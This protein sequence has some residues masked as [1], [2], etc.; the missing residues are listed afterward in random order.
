MKTGGWIDRVS[1]LVTGENLPLDSFDE[2]EIIHITMTVIICNG[3]KAKG[4]KTTS[5]RTTRCGGL[6]LAYG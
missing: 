1:I 3:T 2:S 6:D 4:T 5:S